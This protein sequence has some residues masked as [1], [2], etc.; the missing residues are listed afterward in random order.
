MCIVQLP[1]IVSVS[2][3]QVRRQKT[4]AGLWPPVWGYILSR[5]LYGKS[6]EMTGLSDEDL[7]AV[8]YSMIRAKRM[9]H[10]R[11]TEEEAVRLARYWGADEVHARRS[12]ILHDCT[13]YLELDEQL[14][15]CERYGVELDALE[16]E[17][18]KL[19]HA[20]TGAA[21][22]KYMFGEPDEVFQAIFWH[23]TGKADM[24]LLEKVLYVA[25]YMEPSRD[26]DGVERLREL[27]YTDLDA[28]VLL[29]TE[30][31]VEELTQRGIPVH[32]NTLAARNFLKGTD[33]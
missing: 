31:S 27:A 32:A 18:V 11:G 13:K 5:G 10:I 28:A 21:L 24:A 6:G 23:T 26:F 30:M 17:A 25:D 1:E 4:G 20:K 2:S 7:R 8:S 19:L 15:L 29:G 3:T 9:T 16:R 14:A 33:T 22:A 12:A